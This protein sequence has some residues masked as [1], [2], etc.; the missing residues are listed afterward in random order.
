M[1]CAT[2]ASKVTSAQNAV[3]AANAAYDTHMNGVAI[4]GATMA[5]S[6]AAGAG[7]ATPLLGVCAVAVANLAYH[8]KGA[9]DAI[10]RFSKASLKLIDA[11]SDLENCEARKRI[12]G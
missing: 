4:W 11:E 10:E 3:N 2:E 5:A 12:Y 8:T 1:S 6:C 9:S 7:G